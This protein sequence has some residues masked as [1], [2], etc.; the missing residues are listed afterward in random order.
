M[1][2]QILELLTTQDS[3]NIKIVWQIL[4][5][6]LELKKELNI[7]LEN[8]IFKFTNTRSKVPN[9]ESDFI[10]FFSQVHVGILQKNKHWC[11]SVSIYMTKPVLN[12]CT[13]IDPTS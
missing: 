2:K 1:L 3:A 4:S 12:Y 9:N 10:A 13:K 11:N 8:V 7:W 5:T 6:D